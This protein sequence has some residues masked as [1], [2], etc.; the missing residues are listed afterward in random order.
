[1]AA[2]IPNRKDPEL[3]RQALQKVRLDKE[4]E[5]NDGFDGTWVAHPDLVKTARD[6]FEKRLEGRPHQ[7][8]KI[9]EEHATMLQLV[10]FTIPNG[11]ISYKGIERNITVTLQYLESWL[12]GIGAAAIN[13]LMEDTATAE[14]SRAQLWQ[15][16]HHHATITEDKRTID[17]A[18]I[19]EMI[20]KAYQRLVKEGNGP[21]RQ[22]KTARALLEELVQREVFTPFL[23]IEAYQYLSDEI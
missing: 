23:T 3:N 8:E 5:A 16:I 19:K 4:R 20:E 7:N 18:M 22:W 21:E 17:L 10:D 13:Q 12:R 9:P 1:M 2:F 11:S 14:I 15:W 6:V